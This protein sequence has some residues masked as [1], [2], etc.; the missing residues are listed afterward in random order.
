MANDIVTLSKNG[1]IV[2][3]TLQRPPANAMSV[4]LTEQST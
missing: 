1:P 3:V 4:E 2:T